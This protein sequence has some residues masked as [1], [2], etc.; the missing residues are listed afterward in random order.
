MVSLTETSLTGKPD[1]GNPPVRF[2]GRGSGNAALPTPIFGC[3][4][5]ALRCIA[6]CQ[7]A[8]RAKARE[9]GTAKR[10][11]F[12]TSGVRLAT[13]SICPHADQDSIEALAAALDRPVRGGECPREAPGNSK[14][15]LPLIPIRQ[16]S[17]A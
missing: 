2:G 7:S 6:D 4:F 17:R 16:H 13:F 9:V 12:H 15:H 14:N 10:P 5:A 11:S 1:A 8:R 3:G